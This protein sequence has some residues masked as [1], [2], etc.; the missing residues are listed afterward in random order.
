VDLN[1]WIDQVSEAKTSL[2][3][4]MRHVVPAAVLLN[5]NPRT[6]YS[7]YRRERSP[8]FPA[9]MKIVT[10]SGGAVDYNGIFQP[11]QQAAERAKVSSSGGL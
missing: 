3:Q 11:F 9:A 2:R 4:G 5:E 8:A 6:V 10:I 7:W 1:S